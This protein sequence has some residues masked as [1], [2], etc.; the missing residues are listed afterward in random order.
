MR[1]MYLCLTAT[2]LMSA[3]PITVRA[4][5]D[6]APRKAIEAGYKEYDK[7]VLKGMTGMQKW[8]EQYLAPEFTLVTTDGNSMNHKQYTDMLDHLV[9]NPSPGWKDI[10]SQKT[11]IKKLTMNGADAVA[12]V[13]IETT[14]LSNAPKR[15]RFQ[16]EKTYQET[17]SKVG[18]AWKVKRSE[19][20]E[21]KKAEKPANTKPD[22]PKMPDNRGTQGRRQTPNGLPPHP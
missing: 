22:K 3:T 1:S 4:A 2:I 15:P 19:E 10:K 11:H 12:L 7:M 13:E 16:W 17:W 14:F 9:K 5:E 18:E 20:I 21:T 8:C 6:G